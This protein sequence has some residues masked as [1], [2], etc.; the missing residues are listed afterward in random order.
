MTDGRKHNR[1]PPKPRALS[2][3]DIAVVD[4][5]VHELGARQW[6]VGLKLGV[7]CVTIGHAVNRQG[8]YADVPR[9]TSNAT[10]NGPQ[11]PNER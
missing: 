1:P 6:K 10:L 11:G 8:A 9:Y 2:D 4:H 5:L 3:A 7:S